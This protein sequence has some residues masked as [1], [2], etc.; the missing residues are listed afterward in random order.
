MRETTSLYPPSHPQI[1]TSQ[2]PPSLPLNKGPSVFFHMPIHTPPPPISSHLI[3]SSLLHPRLSLESIHESIHPSI[4]PSSR[5]A[6]GR[7]KKKKEKKERGE[8]EPHLDVCLSPPQPPFQILSNNATT[9]PSSPPRA[10]SPSR[11]PLPKS[12]FIMNSPGSKRERYP[13]S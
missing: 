1:L 10:L 9:T 11:S 4:H 2:F 6:K 3:S 8:G 7:G 13:P 5:G 12:F